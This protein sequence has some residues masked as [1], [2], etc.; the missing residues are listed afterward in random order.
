MISAAT[1]WRIPMKKLLLV[2]LVLGGLFSL[3]ETADAHRVVYKLTTV[4]DGQLGST[5]FQ[6]AIVTIVFEGDTRWV[7][8]E[9]NS[10]GAKVYQNSKGTATVKV[11][12][13]GGKTTVAEFLPGQ[14]FARY[15]VTNGVVGFGSTSGGTYPFAIDCQG[16]DCSKGDWDN[17][18]TDG[19]SV[20]IPG[21][22]A[23]AA[24]DSSFSIYASSATFRLPSNLSQST[25]LTGYVNACFAYDSGWNCPAPPPS[26]LLQTNRGEF[27]VR[28]LSQ[29]GNFALFS[30]VAAAGEE[31]D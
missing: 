24:V 10:N 28:D 26:A 23:A 18:C 5:A 31:N 20:N 2:G 29:A 6:S 7:T 4:T 14:I 15:D 17:C 12:Q 9:T 22:L 21:V 3:N 13:P 8:S 30:V 11:V 16:T 19:V 25:L 27:F 1:L